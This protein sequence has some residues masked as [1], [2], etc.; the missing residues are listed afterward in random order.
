MRIVDLSQPVHT[1]MQVYPGDPEVTLSTVATVVE[2]GYQVASL[3]AGSHTGTH[4]DAPLHSIPGGRAVDAIDLARLVGPARIVRCTG[5]AARETIRWSDVADQLEDLDGIAMVL[6]RTDWSEHFGSERYLEHPVLAAEV[7]EQLLSAG[8][9]VVG[10]DTLNPD[11]TLDNGDELPFHAVL[12]GADGVIV[13]NLT[14][15]AQVTWD[16]PLVSVLPLALAG[17]DG[18]PIRAVAMQQ[19]A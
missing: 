18:A 15:L 9:T 3:H 19:D 14:N 11:A 17:T 6:F 4:L 10:V 5:L 12:L 7:A 2:D 8:I 1:G 13:E 16:R